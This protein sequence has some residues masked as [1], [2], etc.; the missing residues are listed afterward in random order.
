[1]SFLMS[2]RR[3]PYLRRSI[4]SIIDPTPFPV[5]CGKGVQKAQIAPKTPL[6]NEL[7]SKI[8]FGGPITVAEFMKECLT[9][10]RHGYYTQKEDVLGAKGDFVT[11]PEISPMFGESLGIW[12]AN[13]WRK[14]G[15]PKPFQVV[16]FGPGRGTLSS[17]L[18]RTWARVL[19]EMSQSLSEL[20]LVEVSEKMRTIQAKAL[21]ESPTETRTSQGTQVTWHRDLQS[22]PEGFTFYLAHEFL[23]ALPIHKFAQFE[24]QWRE[25]LVAG[26]ETDGGS[27]LRLVRSRHRTPACSFIPTEGVELDVLEICPQAGILAQSISRRI[28]ACGGAALI[29]DYGHFGDKGDTFRAFK[30]HALIDPLSEPGHCDL[31]ADVDFSYIRRHCSEFTTFHG[32]VDQKQFLLSL[33]LQER[34]AQL[35]RSTPDHVTQKQLLASYQKLTEDM[36]TLFKFCAIFPKTMD[37]IHAKYPPAGF[38]NSSTINSDPSLDPA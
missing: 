30:A 22:V 6:V 9:N 28:D 12:F 1:M 33:G 29:A 13:E 21:C 5:G 18:L 36:G 38:E 7:S 15:R 20:H 17:D 4:C 25:I 37:V 31:T 27:T 34:L 19:P 24:S 8:R 26:C 35:I 11:S 10:P 16:E 32:P 23:D 3:A 2:G 14:M